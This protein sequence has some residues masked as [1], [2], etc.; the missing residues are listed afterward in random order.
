M[1]QPFELPGYEILE[2]IG[3]GGTSSVWK[4]RQISLDRIVAIKTLSPVY[5]PDQEALARF[6]QEAQAAARLKHP[7]I[8]QVYDAG[9]SDGRPYLVMEYVGGCTVGD[10]LHRAGRLTER[11]ALL[12]AEGVAQALAYAWDKDC[13]IHLDVKPD[14]VLVEGDGSIKVTDLGLARFIGL[15]RRRQED[16]T[17]LGTPNYVSPEQAEGVIDLDCR[18]DIYSLGAMLYHLVTGRMPF[19]G[20][21]GSAAMDA[22]VQEFL[23][24]P[25]DLNAD[26]KPSTAWFIEKLMVKNR[27]FRPA[28]WSMV[29]SDLAEVKEGRMPHD[30]LPEA[31]QSTILRTVARKVPTPIAARTV[32]QTT[33]PTLPKRRIVLS[34]SASTQSGAERYYAEDSGVGRA[35]IQLL[36]AGMVAVGVILFFSMGLSQ[37][38]GRR[39]AAEPAPEQPAPTP[40]AEQRVEPVVQPATTTPEVNEAPPVLDWGGEAATPQERGMKNGVVVWDNAEFREGA[41]LFNDAYALYTEFQKT[42]QN[43]ADLPRIESL[44]RAAIRKFESVRALAPPDVNVP[45]DIQNCYHLIADVR[46]STLLQ[47]NQPER[48]PRPAPSGPDS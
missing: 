42:R 36:I 22:H 32:A 29:L 15:H 40:L 34:E 46:H 4:A 23:P 21:P 8:V 10:L 41:R 43:R 26:L 45:A 39:P 16:D 38:I 28:Y 19:A 47:P 25:V 2:K 31:G 17:I 5:L 13:I 35:L 48:R 9:E 12:I 20:R 14:N 44:A 7:A 18:T 6:R 11:N 33:K 24:D 37:R 1:Q 27:A 30:P 3:E